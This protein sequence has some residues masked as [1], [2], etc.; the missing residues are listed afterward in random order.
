VIAS[1]TD[2]VLSDPTLGVEHREDLTEV[3]KATDR[4]TALTRQMV[5][6]G[7]TQVLRPA[8]INMNDRLTELLPMLKRLFETTIDIRI[9]A[10]KDLWSV[11]ADPGQMEQVLLNLAINSRDAMPDGG[12]LTFITENRTIDSN[13]SGVGVC[14]N[15]GDYVLLRVRGYRVGMDE[16]T[17][18]KSSSRSSRRK[19]SGRELASASLPHTAS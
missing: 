7:R 1:C 18:R 10:E 11:R 8:T 12:T 15:P 14:M 3:K 6:F 2:F 9:Q 17:Q 13:P 16:E 5:A 19:R 4:A